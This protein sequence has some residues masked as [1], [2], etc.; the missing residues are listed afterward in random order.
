METLIQGKTK[1][2][3]I[4][5]ELGGYET[6]VNYHQKNPSRVESNREQLSEVQTALLMLELE[7]YGSLPLSLYQTETRESSPDILLPHKILSCK[8]NLA[9]LLQGGN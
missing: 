4:E 1:L 6:I 7:V 2:K 3:R 9:K 8:E 5:G